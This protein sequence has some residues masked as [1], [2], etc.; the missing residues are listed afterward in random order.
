MTDASLSKPQVD[1]LSV[2]FYTI[3]F[4]FLTVG[5]VLWANPLRFKSPAKPAVYVEAKMRG[6]QPVRTPQLAPVLTHATFT[7]QC[8]DC[9]DLFPSSDTSGR[10]LSFH[11]DITLAHGINDRCFNCH[12]QTDR[13]AFAGYRTES[14]PFDKPQLLCAK[15]HG[16]VY[17]D[18][19]H[20]VHG[21]TD[22]YWN[23][24]FGPVRRLK[25]IE[26]HDPHTP[27][28]ASLKPA[29]GPNT[30]RTTTHEHD[31]PANHK[32]NRNPLMIWR[33]GEPQHASTPDA[34]RNTP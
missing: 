5:C 23:A 32:P 28:F 25:C 24:Q 10:R 6:T 31:K 3:G 27:A 11:T 4:V 30:L 14:I 8:S 18:W 34:E 20:G 16:P 26:C 21:R 15:C 1:A 9:H 13:N 17:Q 7:Y 12:H 29:P 22:G 2:A 19:L 33:K